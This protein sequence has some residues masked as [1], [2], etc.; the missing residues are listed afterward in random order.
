MAERWGWIEFEVDGPE[1]DAIREAAKDAH[2]D[3]ADYC[4]LMVLAAAG[5]GGVL[6]HLN[7]AVDASVEVDALGPNAATLV[8]DAVEA[9]NDFVSKT[10]RERW[11]AA[12]EQRRL[13]GYSGDDRICLIHDTQ[14]RELEF[15]AEQLGIADVLK[16]G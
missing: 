10:V 16:E 7:R 11:L 2:M 6:E 15:L 1:L 12:R 9:C 5:M 13:A 3:V 14:A 8:T 4:R